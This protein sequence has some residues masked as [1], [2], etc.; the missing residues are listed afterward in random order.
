MKI[1]WKLQLAFHKHNV[2]KKY[3]LEAYSSLL[4]YNTNFNKNISVQRQQ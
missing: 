1:T 4:N 2:K 3:V